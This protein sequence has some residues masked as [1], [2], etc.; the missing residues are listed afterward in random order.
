MSKS[1]LATYINLSPN[2]TKPRNHA[3]D[4]LTPHVVVGQWSAKQIADYFTN[5]N[6]EAA[7]NYGIGKDGE[8][9]LCVEEENRSWCTSSRDNDHRAITVEIASDKTE[10]YAVTDKALAA[11]ID[12]F[13][14]VCKRNG[15]TKVLW[16]GDK[17]KTLSYNPASHE[18]VITVH[19][20]FANK[21]CPGSYV[22]ERLGYVADE[23]NKRLTGGYS[24]GDIV[25][26]TG[27]KH[28]VSAWS[29][30]GS[31]RKPGKAKVTAV[32]MNGIHQYHLVAITGGGSDVYGWVDADTI[33]TEDEKKPVETC[34]LEI[35]VLSKG[36]K[37]AQVKAMQTLLIGYGYTCGGY[38]ADGDFGNGTDM[39]LRNYQK[40]K[41]LGVDGI[42]GSNTWAKLLGTA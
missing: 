42:C 17:D 9:S 35:P 25:N 31:E 6:I 16:F 26:F 4:T 19:R 38:G 30:D 32:A 21:S 27:G 34:K 10:P 8:I 29:N 14:D 11:L 7:P 23:I 18:M 3:I 37:G 40:D 2:C 5:P 41:K 1:K 20:W 36:S 12:L 39:A 15:K 33:R 28:Y 13:T 24:V 22:Y